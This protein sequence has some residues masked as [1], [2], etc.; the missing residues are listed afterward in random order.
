MVMYPEKGE[1]QSAGIL[2]TQVRC[3]GPGGWVGPPHGG[4]VGYGTISSQ[5]EGLPAFGVGAL[6]NSWGAGT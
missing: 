3:G 6:V 5:G 4:G 2:M 1:I